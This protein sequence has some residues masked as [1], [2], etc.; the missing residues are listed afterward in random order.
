M[1]K[2]A[3]KRRQL[4]KGIF[5]ISEILNGVWGFC[6]V[7]EENP[8][9]D[10]QLAFW[11]LGLKN[12]SRGIEFNLSRFGKFTYGPVLGFDFNFSRDIDFNLGN[13]LLVLGL[14]PGLNYNFNLII[15]KRASPYS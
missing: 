7:Q 13:L 4:K 15:F 8:G 3:H 5:G 14:A 1:S 12:M 10:S 2:T 6:W 11:P 9:R